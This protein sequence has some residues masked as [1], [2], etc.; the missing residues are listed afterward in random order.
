LNQARRAFVLELS[1]PPHQ[2][3]R[4][5][6]GADFRVEYDCGDKEAK[7]HDSEANNKNN[8][9]AHSFIALVTEA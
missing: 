1:N 7:S 4:L 2:R 8:H 6:A 5:R 3:R 9:R